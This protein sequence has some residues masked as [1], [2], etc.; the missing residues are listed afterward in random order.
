M[1]WLTI[2]QSGSKTAKSQTP[3]TKPV[4]NP[5]LRRDWDAKANTFVWNAHS[6]GQTAFQI[7]NTLVKKGYTV[8]ETDV[9]D[10]LHRQ[11]EAQKNVPTF[12]WNAQADKFA[13]A[14]ASM[15]HPVAQITA[16]LWENGYRATTADVAASLQ[17]QG[18]VYIE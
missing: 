3:A 2:S 9:A 11:K 4:A 13:A 12:C 10:I 8:T 18:L 14:A 7:V 1:H 17:R 6:Y 5:E 15:G 16:K